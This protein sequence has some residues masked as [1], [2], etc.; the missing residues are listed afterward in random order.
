M[1]APLCGRTIGGRTVVAAGG[2]P[3]LVA[4]IMPLHGAQAL[5]RVEAGWPWR[6]LK[7]VRLWVSDA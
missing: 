1:T 5:C 3:P 7:V 2:V 6:Y 4:I